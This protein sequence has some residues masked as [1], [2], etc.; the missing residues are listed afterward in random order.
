MAYGPGA[1]SLFPRPAR[2]YKTVRTPAC[3]RI[4]GS[5]LR[6]R[7][8]EDKALTAR[9]MERS[10]L[11][12]LAA[13]AVTVPVAATFPLSE[14]AAAYE[15]FAAGGKLGKIVLVMEPPPA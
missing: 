7:S 14:V 4:C 15:R 9:R 10:V 12:L 3:S 8:L 2:S 5:T 6:R 1:G 11:P 13:G